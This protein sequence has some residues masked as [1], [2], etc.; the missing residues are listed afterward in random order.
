[1]AKAVS[2]REVVA[3][4]V[5]PAGALIVGLAYFWGAYGGISLD[6]F[7]FLLWVAML[8]YPAEVIV[9]LP[10]HLFLKRRRV[11]RRAAYVLLGAA[12]GVAPFIVLTMVQGFPLFP[13]AYVGVTAGIASA[14]VFWSL[15][16]ARREE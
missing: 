7:G 1:M 5:A 15:A 6:V 12:A 3:L 13:W 16:V 11:D 2:R 4:A 10:G 9:A 8:A 14:L